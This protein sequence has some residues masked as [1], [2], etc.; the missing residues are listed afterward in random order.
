VLFLDP[1]KFRKERAECFRG[2]IFHGITCILQTVAAAKPRN[3][4]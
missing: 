2:N 4:G 1:A 3:Q